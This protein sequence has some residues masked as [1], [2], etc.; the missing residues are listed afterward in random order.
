M[1][2]ATNTAIEAVFRIEQAR[3]I[4]RLTRLTRDV[5]L[6]E[7]L[8]QNALVAA[9][10][11]W[12]SEGVPD[13][14]A[15]WLMSTA[16]RRGIDLVRHRAMTDRKQDD[17]SYTLDLSRAEADLET[18]LD[19]D[20]EDDLLRLVFIACHPVLSREAQVA[21]TLRLLGGLTIAEIA[22]A[23]LTAETTIQQRIVRAKK[24]LAEKQIAFELPRG[25]DRAERLASVLAVLYLIFNE[26]YSATAGDDLVRPGLCEDALRLGRILTG[27]A[28]N[29]A[30]THGLV[31]LMELQASRIP[32]RVDKDGEP[33][34][35]ADQNRSRWDFT[36][37]R[38]GLGELAKA[39]ALGGGIYTLQAAIAA[40]HARAPTP[41]A[42]DWQ[43][44]SALYEQLADATGSPIVE[45]NRAVAIGMAEGPEAGLRHCDTLREVES[46]ASYH[47]Y[48]AVRADFLTKLGRNE[49]AFS[50]LQRAAELTQNAREKKLLLDRAAAL[51]S[52]LH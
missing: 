5:G 28:P 20:I 11:Q 37:I 49:D 15:A 2:A 23:F 42:T 12:P 30:E 32:T 22:R 16:K 7:E 9:L 44:I 19:N 8:A 21:M 33:I 46:L 1:D 43:R 24:T 6:A 41:E 50:A 34:L 18:A 29:D 47:L 38:H 52:S 3:L 4:A 39:E 48:F 27:L 36:L 40:C 10:E 14:P 45:L 31:A 17:L 35:L 51:P 25:Q 13:K 26:G